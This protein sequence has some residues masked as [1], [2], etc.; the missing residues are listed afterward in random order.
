[1][2]NIFETAQTFLVNVK[3]IWIYLFFAVF[4]LFVY[5]RGCSETRK[6]RSAIFDSF[7]VSIILGL[8][9]GRISYLVINW[10]EYFR[11]PWS[12]LPYERY[13]DTIYIFRLLP[14]RLIRVW[15]G[16]LTIFVSMIAILLALTL[17]VLIIK[18]WRPYQIY[19][20]IFFSVIVMLGTSF[21]YL[22]LVTNTNIWMITGVVLNLIPLIFWGISKVLLFSIKNGVK[23]RKTLVYIGILLVTTTSLAISYLYIQDT[24][25]QFEMG[26]VIALI[27]WT[28][29]MD[30]SVI[31]DVNRPNVTIERVSSVRAVDIEI[32]QPL[33]L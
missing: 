20:P 4:G 8:I 24:V 33:K 6:H 21:I 10:S 11:Y 2:Q 15:D 30:I 14:W 26:A 12:Y 18:K 32:N 3:P 7:F 31:I 1:M 16:G 29:V 5:W 13:G 17:F 22:G 19:F 28:A 27:L 25:S 23:R 9:V